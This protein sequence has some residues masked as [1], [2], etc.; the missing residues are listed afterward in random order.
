MSDI[1]IGEIRAFPY[2]YAPEGWMFCNGQELLTQQYQALFSIIGNRFGGDGRRTFNL[3]NMVVD[4]GSGLGA[5]PLGMG[6]GP[7][8]TPR[9]LGPKAYGTAAVTLTP[10]E[11]PVHTHA[12]QTVNL[13][14]P[15]LT[16][17]NPKNAFVVRGTIN[18]AAPTP[19]VAFA[20]FAP[21]NATEMVAFREPATSP[22]GGGLPHENRQ[23][24]LPMNFCIAIDGDYPIRP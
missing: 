13:V 9:H 18:N 7:G 6:T 14:D 11:I 10:A 15:N 16:I 19:D 24:V 4:A 3:P 22:T 2:D 17:A 1:F 12:F 8:L 23:P 5:A 20:A 21:L